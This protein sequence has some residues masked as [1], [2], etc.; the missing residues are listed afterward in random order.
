MSKKDDRIN[1]LVELAKANFA[2]E[3]ENAAQ[4]VRLADINNGE[5]IACSLEAYGADLRTTAK[6]L[7]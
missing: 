6:W 1:Q 2:H 4:Y 3:M 7:S 5:M